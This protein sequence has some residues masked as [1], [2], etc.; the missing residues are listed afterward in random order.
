MFRARSACDL[1]EKTINRFWGP[2][3]IQWPGAGWACS[4]TASRPGSRASSVVAIVSGLSTLVD[5][6]FLRLLLRR[7]TGQR[8]GRDV[9][10]DDRSR[11]DPS[12]VT[13]RNRSSERIVHTGPDVPADRRRPLGLLR[14]VRE[15][16]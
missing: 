1:P 6:S 16:G 14:V 8:A 13:H 3:S 7:E 15:V 10:R 4:V 9:V 11:P 5:P 12:V 2:R